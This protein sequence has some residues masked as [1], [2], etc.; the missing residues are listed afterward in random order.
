MILKIPDLKTDDNNQ[1]LT[2]L[3]ENENSFWKCLSILG[4]RVFYPYVNIVLVLDTPMH[5]KINNQINYIL[6]FTQHSEHSEHSE[7]GSSKF[8][9][10]R[11]LVKYCII[12]S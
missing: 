12:I 6:V 3:T 7:I 2:A 1:Y 11:K 5:K 9:P 4:A 10:P 8:P